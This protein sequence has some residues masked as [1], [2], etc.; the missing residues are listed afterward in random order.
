VVKL[1]VNSGELRVT[2]GS[3]G[4]SSQSVHMYIPFSGRGTCLKLVK[5]K[6]SL[7][8]KSH[9]DGCAPV[10]APGITHIAWVSCSIYD[11]AALQSTKDSM[12]C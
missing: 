7:A 11:I 2:G 9:E 3:T 10:A 8:A 6:E 4:G 1:Q 12:L 5:K